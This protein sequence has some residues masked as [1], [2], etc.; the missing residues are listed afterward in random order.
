ML[1]TRKLLRLALLVFFALFGPSHI[2]TAAQAQGLDELPQ[3]LLS[4]WENHPTL[5][6]KRSDR[7]AMRAAVTVAERQFWP[8]PSVS[9]DV[10]PADT[11]G[12]TQ[13]TTA[14]LSYPLFTGGQLT[15][16][17]EIA[18]L[19]H[20]I[21]ETEI[22]IAGREL[23]LQF[24]DLYRAWWLHSAR[25]DNHQN[26][27]MQMDRL[28]QM[29]MRRANAGV[30]AKQDLALADLHWQRLQDEYRQA[31][32]QRDQVLADMVTFGGRDMQPSFQPIGSWPRAP[33]AQILDLTE[34][35]LATHPSMNLSQWQT[36]LAQAELKRA[37]ANV[38]P[39][40]TLKLEKQYGAYQGTQAPASRVYLNSQFTMG[41]GLAAIPFQQQAMARATAA[42]L[43]ADAT[44]LT[45]TSQV[46][47]LWHERAQASEQINSTQRQLKLQKDLADSGLRLFTSGR[48]SWQDLLNLQ[49]ELHQLQAQKSEAEATYLAADWRL[50]L[51]ANTLPMFSFPSF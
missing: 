23:V 24:I 33:Y 32:K 20:R 47:R 40:V 49:R 48:R 34:R 31:L 36:A 7:N 19:K 12:R 27:L 17:L 50:H 38:L 46:Q 39:S 8:T 26:A 10:G 29:L 30:S 21:A 22:E 25:I 35:V 16:D 41:A 51:L 44:R 15:A 14:R 6:A 3:L 11:Q 18:D 1:K 28:R 4:V 37:K 13:A 5:K 45:L 9:N 43:Q 42:E 2:S